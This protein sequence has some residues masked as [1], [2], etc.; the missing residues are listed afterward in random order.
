MKEPIF[1]SP[2]LKMGSRKTGRREPKCFKP[3]GWT[4]PTSCSDLT[5]GTLVHRPPSPQIKEVLCIY[6]ILPHIRALNTWSCSPQ[7]LSGH[8]PGMT[9]PTQLAEA[10]LLQGVLPDCDGDTFPLVLNSSSLALAGPECCLP[11]P[12]SSLSDRLA[13][14]A[15]R[16]GKTYV[17]QPWGAVLLQGPSHIHTHAH[18]PHPGQDSP[19]VA[20]LEPCIV[21]YGLNQGPGFNPFLGLALIF[22]SWKSSPIA[23][24]SPRWLSHVRPTAVA[25]I[26]GYKG[27]L[28]N[29]GSIAHTL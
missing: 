27:V 11:S 6:S 2:Q 25:E 5:P 16:L 26:T 20:G 7:A 18:T 10:H 15:P 4:S 28:C 24:S 12:A 17:C 9:H 8:P 13:Y 22:D 29:M 1:P 23:K 3:E 19:P 21:S 14:P